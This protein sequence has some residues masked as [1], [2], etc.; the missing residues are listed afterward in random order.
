MIVKHSAYQTIRYQF[1]EAL[2]RE[3]RQ[4]TL[5]DI[6]K[7]RYKEWKAWATEHAVRLNPVSKLIQEIMKPIYNPDTE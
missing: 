7:S 6:Q 2:D 3:I 5:N 1:I 4:H